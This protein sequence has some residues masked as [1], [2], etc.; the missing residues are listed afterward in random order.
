MC[1]KCVSSGL[2][3]GRPVSS[4]IRE[5][6]EVCSK[7][8]SSLWKECVKWV[9]CVSSVCQVYGKSVSSG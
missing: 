3:G 7:C 8:V 4:E 9:K 2:M 5:M 6:C 1:V